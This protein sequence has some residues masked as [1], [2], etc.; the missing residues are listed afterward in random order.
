MVDMIWWYA[1]PEVRGELIWQAEHPDPTS[2]TTL[3]EDLLAAVQDLMVHWAPTTELH[4]SYVRHN[5]V[6]NWMVWSTVASVDE[7]MVAA[8][9]LEDETNGESPVEPWGIDIAT[10]PKY[11]AL[12][13][14][15]VVADDDTVPPINWMERHN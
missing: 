11:G 8:Y 3:I 13:A 7:T 15:Y 10:L 9:V 2:P 1:T 14:G 12:P 5:Q 4:E 6:L